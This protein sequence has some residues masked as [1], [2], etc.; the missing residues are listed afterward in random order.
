MSPRRSDPNIRALL[1]DI[2][3]RLLH[4]EGPKALSTRRVTAEA[5]CSTMMVYSH[6]GGMSGL[7]REMVHE[8]FARLQHHF[9]H[10]ADTDD[11]VADMALLGRAYRYN[12]QANP[13]L[14]AV[15]FGGASLSSFSLSEADRRHGRYTLGNV[16]RCGERCI[17]AGR[18]RTED[19]EL[20][21]HQMW[22]GVHGL[23][24]LER[25]EYLIAPYDAD[26]CFEALLTALM[27]AVGDTHEAAVR[28]V[29]VS[30]ERLRHEIE[31]TTAE[32]PVRS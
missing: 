26:L 15:M 18:F 8:G 12:A 2:A 24:T 29:E 28:S 11:P 10:V 4:E 31:T 17:A 30:R 7:V 20:I 19:A 27:V 25:G 1:V 21:A 22:S 9:S 13:D 6:F 5:G 23:V 32:V 16:I 3:A 14:Y